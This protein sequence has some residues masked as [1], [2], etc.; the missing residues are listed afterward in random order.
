M[1]FNFIIYDP[2]ALDKNRI[3]KFL[4]FIAAKQ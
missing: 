4:H 3:L 2:L 1:E